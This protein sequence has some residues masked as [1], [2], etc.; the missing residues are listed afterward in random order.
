MPATTFQPHKRKSTTSYYDSF[1]VKMATSRNFAL[2]CHHDMLQRMLWRDARK[3]IAQLIQQS[4]RVE[5]ELEKI[6]KI[7]PIVIDDLNKVH[8][9]R[10]RNLNRVYLNIVNCYTRRQYNNK[11]RW[12][13]MVN[14]KIIP[15]RPTKSE[16]HLK[17][18]ST[19]FPE[20][21]H[22]TTDVGYT[23]TYNRKADIYENGQAAHDRKC[24]S[25]RAVPV[26]HASGAFP[27]PTP[28]NLHHWRPPVEEE[29]DDRPIW[30]REREILLARKQVGGTSNQS[31]HF[32]GL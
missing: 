24:M 6:H 16:D 21:Y 32:I 26:G 28:L 23:Y 11:N 1:N 19:A 4:K 25:T 14:Q 18:V 10:E 31:K 7:F 12:Q 30:I 27:L 13:E 9:E 2:Q 3:K 5:R 8:K 15:E 20:V 22:K 17:F 29:T